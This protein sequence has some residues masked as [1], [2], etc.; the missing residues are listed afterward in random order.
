VYTA[1]KTR[2]LLD[3]Y[4][5]LSFSSGVFGVSRYLPKRDQKQVSGIIGG[6]QIGL[7]HVQQQ[8]KSLQE[9]LVLLQA[10]LDNESEADQ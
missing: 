8:D 1:S 7:R 9:Q 5:H 4:I 2:S 10:A 3:L 6:I